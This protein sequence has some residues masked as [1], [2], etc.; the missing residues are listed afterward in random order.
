M[1]LPPFSTKSALTYLVG[2]V[3]ALITI[4]LLVIMLMHAKPHGRQLEPSGASQGASQ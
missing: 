3:A 4:I 1:S 2:V